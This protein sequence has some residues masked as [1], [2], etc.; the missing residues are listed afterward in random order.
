MNT[1]IF[2]I[3]ILIL[4]ILTLLPIIIKYNEKHKKRNEDKYHNSIKSLYRQC[5]RWAVASAQ[6]NSTIIRVLH[7]NYATGYLWAL[8]DIVDSSEFKNITGENWDKFE[9]RIVNIQD[10]STNEL[11]SKWDDPLLFK[12]IY[13]KG[14]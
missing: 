13:S 10:I 1:E 9:E 5:A 12:A 7:A 3:L 2:V 14:T 11:V 4:V 8:K 6:D